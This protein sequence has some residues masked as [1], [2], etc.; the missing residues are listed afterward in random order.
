MSSRITHRIAFRLAATVFV[1]ALVIGE[2]L[3]LVHIAL[4][5]WN[6]RTSMEAEIGRMMNNTRGASAE[7]L[8]RTDRLSANQIIRGFMNL[9]SVYAATL[10]DSFGLP[11]SSMD[12]SLSTGEAD[13]IFRTFAEGKR[14]FLLPIFAEGK[15]EPVGS[16][17]VSVDTNYIYGD[18]IRRGKYLMMGA[19]LT[20]LLIGAATH[21]IAHRRLTRNLEHLRGYVRAAALGEMP[22]EALELPAPGAGQELDT[23]ALAVND[24]TLSLRQQIAEAEWKTRRAR[25]ELHQATGDTRAPARAA[26]QAP[27]DDLNELDQRLRLDTSTRVLLGGADPEGA[28]AILAALSLADS[29]RPGLCDAAAVVVESIALLSPCSD[30][31]IRLHTSTAPAPC[32]RRFPRETLMRWISAAPPS[33][34]TICPS[35]APQHRDGSGA[36]PIRP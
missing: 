34:A 10:V 32:R 17:Q 12:R 13:W 4:D 23:L 33:P 36:L 5:Y 11:L 19:L 20:A 7:A 22:P 30:I 9:N 16:V 15:I 27:A 35:A 21:W 24:F 3:S 2:L 8:R 28:A 26:P 14:H 1:C 25:S 29:D 31:S 6:A 18:A